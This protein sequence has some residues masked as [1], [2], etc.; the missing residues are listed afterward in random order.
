MALHL[1]RNSLWL[2]EHC[3]IATADTSIS[4]ARHMQAHLYKH[5]FGWIM[6]QSSKCKRWDFQIGQF[7]IEPLGMVLQRRLQYWMGGRVEK[8]DSVR[9]IE[10]IASLARL[11]AP[12]VQWACLK[13]V[14]NCWPTTSRTLHCAASCR[15]GC[16]EPSA[17]DSQRHYCHCP[18]LEDVLMRALPALPK[19]GF[20]QLLLLQEGMEK[21]DCEM[22][23][24][25]HVI[26]AH[27]IFAQ[28]EDGR[29]HRDTL[30]SMIA[31]RCRFLAQR[32]WPLR[33]LVLTAR[34]SAAL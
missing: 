10:R 23:A 2:L 8:D 22:V 15:L 1:L 33:R 31:A 34:R 9:V 6:E 20:D 13:F 16:E 18:I 32:S 25:W 29:L 4:T 14:C 19:F 3:G 12:M 27:I 26:S 21:G 30:H 24:L 17:F 28:H 7:R 11:K 5:I